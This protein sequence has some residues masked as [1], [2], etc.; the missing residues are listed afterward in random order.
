MHLHNRAIHISIYNT[1]D[2]SVHFVVNKH[3]KKK[4]KDLNTYTKKEEQLQ[5]RT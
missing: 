3:T 4:L 5:A 2:A 1:D